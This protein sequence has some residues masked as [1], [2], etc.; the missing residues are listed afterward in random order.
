MSF[1]VIR[2]TQRYSLVDHQKLLD[3]VLVQQ[4]LG[5]VL[6]DAL[7]HGDELILGHQLGHALPRVGGKPHVAIGQDADQLA[8]AC[9]CRRPRPP[10][11]RRCCSP[12]SAPAHRQASRSGWMVSGLTTMPDSNFFTWRTWA[13]CSSG[14]RLRWMTP[15]PPACA[16]AIAILN[17]V[18]V[19]I[20]E[21]MI[22]MLSAI[23]AGDA[24]ADVDLGRQHVRQAGLEQHVVEG[25]APRGR[26]IADRGHSQLQLTRMPGSCGPN[27]DKSVV[28]RGLA[29]SPELGP[30]F[31]LA[32][33]DST[34]SG[35]FHREFGRKFPIHPPHPHMI[36]LHS[37]DPGVPPA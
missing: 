31:G 1:T 28:L 24:G 25:E 14:S 33:V 26:G 20:A 23:A 32:T 15:M 22:G 4:P 19:S 16:M 10:G 3:A 8:G 5:L 21:A 27:T 6:A 7:A 34:A 36:A 37:S 2:P 18:T 12:S 17:S 30:A 11:C 29:S 35:G 9:R 13:A